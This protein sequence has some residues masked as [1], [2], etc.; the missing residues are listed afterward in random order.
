MK[1]RRDK[2]F[3]NKSCSNA[4]HNPK[5]KRLNDFFK[6]EESGHRKS[7]VRLSHL[8]K[9]EESKWFKTKTLERAGVN[10]SY[11]TRR[12]DVGTY[13]VIHYSSDQLLL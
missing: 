11:I 8:L 4:F 5:N 6:K 2:K 7:Y 1:G 10:L 9:D 12:M 13:Q 3:C